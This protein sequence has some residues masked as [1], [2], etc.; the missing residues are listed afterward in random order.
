MILSN[1]PEALKIKKWIL[2]Y[3][4]VHY[5][6]IDIDTTITLGDLQGIVDQIDA[7]INGFI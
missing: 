7:H 3:A 1:C 4:W 5:M 6:G 2:M